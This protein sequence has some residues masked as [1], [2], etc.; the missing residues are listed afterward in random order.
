MGEELN[1][2]TENWIKKAENDLQNVR[3]NFLAD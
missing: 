3:N 1:E 2:Y